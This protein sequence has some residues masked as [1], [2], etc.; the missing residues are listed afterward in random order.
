MG[1]MKD[2]GIRANE[3]NRKARKKV[4]KL[5]HSNKKVS[6]EVAVLDEDAVLSGSEIDDLSEVQ[7]FPYVKI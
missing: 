2:L 5:S 3:G 1:Q 6:D 4:K 7:G